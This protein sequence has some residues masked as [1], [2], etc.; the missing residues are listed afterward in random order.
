[1]NLKN[2]LV[3]IVKQVD[4]IMKTQL[5]IVFS[6]YVLI[7]KTEE[8][9]NELEKVPVNGSEGSQSVFEK[10]TLQLEVLMEMDHSFCI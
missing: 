4:R 6:F 5:C 1:M 7:T 3:C 10:Q 8:I 9:A 2:F